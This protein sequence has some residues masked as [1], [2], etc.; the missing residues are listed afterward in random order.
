VPPEEVESL[1]C[2]IGSGREFDI[3][4]NYKEGM[5]VRVKRGP[6]AGAEGILKNKEDHSVFLVNIDI[7]GR[8]VGVKVYADD[9]ES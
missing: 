4:P 6:L 1:K 9:L 8:S 2:L 3:Y 5:Y 7:L